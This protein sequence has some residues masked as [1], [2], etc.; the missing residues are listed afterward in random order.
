M[1]RHSQG[2]ERQARTQRPVRLLLTGTYAW[3]GHTLSASIPFVLSY[4]EG[5][6]WVVG[7]RVAQPKSRDD[8]LAF[9][10]CEVKHQSG[11]KA[12]RKPNPGTVRE[13][14]IVKMTEPL[15]A[16]FS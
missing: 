13:A 7:A 15:S 16:S 12:T 3:P 5:L 14:G 6:W 2:L 1:R 10:S 9:P 8:G 4:S 11:F